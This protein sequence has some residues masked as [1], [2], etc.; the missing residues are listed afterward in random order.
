MG[1]NTPTNLA[2]QPGSPSPQTNP[3][4]SQRK[5][6]WYLRW[7]MFVV[8]FFVFII[9]IGTVSAPSSPNQVRPVQKNTESG[10]DTKVEVSNT[11]NAPAASVVSEPKTNFADGIH[12]VGTEIQPGTYR[13]RKASSGCYYSRLSGFGGSLSEV[14]SNEN[15]DAPAVVTIDP[16]DAGFKSSRCGSWTQDLSA[17]TTDKTTFGDGIFIVNTDIEPG[18]YKN[19]GHEGC[20]YSRLSGFS[21]KLDNIISNE[22]TDSA[23]VVT[24]AATDKGFKSSRCGDWQ[25]VK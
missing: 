24:I 8:Y 9:V 5:K 16:T 25:K 7:Y 12:V 4:R 23:A 1:N 21:G 19:S 10:G 2:S 17:I 11:E 22:N 15:T 20:Y 3:V 13:T 14:I 18:T 6:R